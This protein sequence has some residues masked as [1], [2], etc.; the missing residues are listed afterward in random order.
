MMGCITILVLGFGILTRGQKKKEGFQRVSG[1]VVGIAHTMAGQS[2]RHEGKMRYLQVSGYSK[3][4]ELFIGKDPGDFSPAF[5]ALDKLKT[6]DVVTV[7]YDEDETNAADAAVVNRLAQFIDQGQQP[8]FIRGSKDKYGGY[9]F[10]S[11]AACMGV[12]LLLLK[13]KGTIV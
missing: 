1:S 3:P 13:K 10:I 6:G 12:G 11:L 8:Y 5:E 2:N 4:F 9:F 7:Y